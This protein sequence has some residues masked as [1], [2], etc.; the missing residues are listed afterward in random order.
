MRPS[1]S[2]WILCACSALALLIT[3]GCGQSLYR[4][5]TKLAADGSIR[6]AIYQ[7]ADDTTALAR[8]PRVWSGVT[9]A[10]EI[11]AEKWRG[12]IRDLP[13]AEQNKE[14]S[15]F[16]AWGQ[17]ASADK[18]PDSYIKPAPRGLPDGKLVVKYERVDHVLVVEH[19]WTE[20]L[21]DIVTLDDMHRSRRQFLELAIPLADKCLQVGLG[22]D[23]DTSG[24]VEW[25][26]ATGTDWFVELTDAFFEAGTRGQLPPNGQWKQ[27]MA[28]VCARYGLKLRDEQGQIFDNDRARA[29]VADFAAGILRRELKRRDGA[30]VPQ[31]AIDDLLEWLNLKDNSAADTPRLA[32]LDGLAQRVI[33]EQFGSQRNF[34]ELVAPL[35]ARMLGLY[36]VDILGPPRYFHYEM[37]LPGLVVETNGVLA[38]ENRV[39]WDFEAVEA[40]PFGYAMEC[41]S[42]VPQEALQRELLGSEPL[43][44][45]DDMLQFVADVSKDFLLRETLRRSVKEKSTEPLV[46]AR[47]QIASENGDTEAF[48]RVMKLLGLGTK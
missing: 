33:E 36:R 22:P 30:A 12:S 48:D 16:A 14:R 10:P 6:R 26:N 44:A 27:S 19:R 20:T 46:A 8:D 38:G 9:Y 13:P 21:T 3:A 7:P 24:I 2:G 4:A 41:R 5:E 37:E 28:D 31:A 11:R 29:A 43:T 25:M 47:R 42:L 45:R 34:Q 17:F 39:E 32:R 1:L 35:G 15:Y 40:Y 23:Y 18:L